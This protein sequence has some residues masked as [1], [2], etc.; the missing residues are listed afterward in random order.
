ME[1]PYSRDVITASRHQHDDEQAIL[2]LRANRER[3]GL[4]TRIADLGRTT[5]TIGRIEDEMRA[6]SERYPDLPPYIQIVDEIVEAI[7]L[8]K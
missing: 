5:T 4:F 8:T 1:L 3:M 6:R 2:A 7:E